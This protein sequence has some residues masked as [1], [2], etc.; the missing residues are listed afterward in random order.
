MNT[1]NNIQQTYYNEFN[2]LL[3]N[4]PQDGNDGGLNEHGLFFLFSII[5]KLNPNTVIE[6]GNWKGI[7]TWLIELAAPSARLISI[8]PHTLKYD[9]NGKWFKYKSKKAEYEGKDFL[10]Q[11]FKSIEDKEKCLVFF[12]DHQDHG[13]RLEHC[14]KLGFKHILLDDNYKSD[15][16]SHLSLF[17]YQNFKKYQNKLNLNIK[18]EVYYNSFLET[19]EYWPHAKKPIHS[20]MTYLKLH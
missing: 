9:K 20:N 2:H 7:S 12:D 8:D 3:K 14:Q 10:E 16:G 4:F 11:N 15:K 18:E 6:S 5:N 1:E 19:S 13:P 17:C